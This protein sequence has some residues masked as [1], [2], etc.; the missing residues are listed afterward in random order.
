MHVEEVL[1]NFLQFFVDPWNVIQPALAYIEQLL[2]I[3][4][5]SVQSFQSPPFI[6]LLVDCHVYQFLHL[7]THFCFHRLLGQIMG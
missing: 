3:V 7:F 6:F 4:K 1:A 2:E 5:S